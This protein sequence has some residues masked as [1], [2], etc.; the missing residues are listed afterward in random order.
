MNR[1]WG[2]IE[3][4]A[5]APEIEG[6]YPGLRPFLAEEAE[7][8]FGREQM[9]D[10]VLVRLNERHMVV[11]HG[12]SGCGKSSLIAAGVLPQLAKRRARRGL[13]LNVG[14]FRPGSRPMQSLV[15]TIAGEVAGG[16][17]PADMQKVYAAIA[18]RQGARPELARLAKAAG[19]D[20]LCIIVDQFEELF[21]FA[22]DESFEEAERFAETLVAL[23]GASD[24][25]ADWWEEGGEGDGVLATEAKE[26]Q[27]SFLLTMRSEFLGDCS[28][29]PRLA[30]AINRTQY[31]LPN[32]ERSDLI[33]AIREPAEVFGGTVDHALAEKIADDAGREQDPLP[34]VQ[35]ALMKLW[36]ASD[37]G[38]LDLSGYEQALAASG[39]SEALRQKSPLSAILA[40]HADA[41]LAQ[42][43]K[44]E[45]DRLAATG[46]IF[47]ALTRKDSE[48]RAIRCPQRYAR[49]EKVSGV[50]PQVT[51]EIVDCF[52]REG[53]SF[54]TPYEAMQA[55]IDPATVIDIS[56]EALIR[57]WPR[58]SDRTI[59]PETAQPVGWLEREAQEAMVWRWLVLHAKFFRTNNSAYLDGTTTDRL[60]DWFQTVKT[61]PEWARPYLLHGEGKED[62]R[63]EP[64]WKAV[65]GLLEESRRRTWL[66]RNMVRRWKKLGWWSLVLLAVALVGVV[67]AGV[68]GYSMW[69]KAQALRSLEAARQS[70]ANSLYVTANVTLEKNTKR[71]AGSNPA[72][73]ELVDPGVAA[74]ASGGAEGTMLVIN[75]KSGY[76]WIGATR[77]N[78]TLSHI[79]RSDGRS[80]P[81]AAVERGGSYRIR[82]NLTVRE[83]PPGADGQPAEAIGLIADNTLVTAVE[84]PIPAPGAAGYWLR[85]LLVPTK[86]PNVRLLHA[87][88]EETA[89]ASA[90]NFTDLGYSVAASDDASARGRWEVLYCREEDRGAALRLAAIASRELAQTH[91]LEARTVAPVRGSDCPAPGEPGLR[92]IVDFS[93]AAS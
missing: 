69:S 83:G 64:E 26:A 5:G 15:A 76:I 45:S 20:Q 56:H 38:A 39:Q 89:A 61:R 9:A 28:R 68:Q 33:R 55:E 47:R 7:I 62:V 13:T 1:A 92:L 46:F 25:P 81:P 50:G 67:A 73:D 40:D 70:T 79:V 49:L 44:G 59:D 23:A 34:L 35:H 52:R 91:G 29:Y 72:E 2:G 85:A 54:L 77:G 84:P 71:R 90:G 65:D 22:E 12:T 78:G 6:P 42:A 60:G 43:T 24:R 41:V 93:A 48:G 58:M 19:I 27:I 66:E 87:G 86:L 57:T 16:T 37:N 82:G 63:E 8:F 21:R 51:R 18:Q 36:R 74:V 11:V 3:G 31:L 32:M 80:L 75:R 88:D 4:S 14:S 17:A 53:V 30:E 10:E